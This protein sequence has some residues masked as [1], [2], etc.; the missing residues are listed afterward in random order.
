MSV[1]SEIHQSAT[2]LVQLIKDGT[3]S[4]EEAVEMMTEEFNLDTTQA[5][6]FLSDVWESDIK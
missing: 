5:R 1:M 4:M 3:I 6:V 2:E